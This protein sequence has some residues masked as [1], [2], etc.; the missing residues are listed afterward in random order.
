MSAPSSPVLRDARDRADSVG[1]VSPDDEGMPDLPPP[2]DIEALRAAAYDAAAPHPELPARPAG[3]DLAPSD[4]APARAVPLRCV[5]ANVQKSSENMHHCL[6]RHRDD[7]VILFA[8]PFHGF[9]KRVVSTTNKDGDAYEGSVAHRNFMFLRAADDARVCAFVHKRWSHLSPRITP[10]RGGPCRDVL[11]LS[12]R[13]D[14]HDLHILTVYNDSRTQAAVDFLREHV[15]SVPPLAYM[16]GDFNLRHERWDATARLPGAERRLAAKCDELIELVDLDL[17]LTLANDSVACPPTWLSNDA[18]K[19]PGTL[20]LLWAHPDLLPDD[21]CVRDDERHRSDHCVLTWTIPVQA[22][23]QPRRT[24][25]RGSPQGAAFVSACQDVL[26]SL[27]D[28]F[29][30]YASAADV[31]AAAL[32]VHEG[33]RCAWD[34]HSSLSNPTAR[35]KSWW[36]AECTTHHVA[37]RACQARMRALKRRRDDVYARMGLEGE[38]LAALESIQHLTESIL[39]E[40]R[41]SGRINGAKRGAMRRAKRTFF[42]SQIERL[43]RSRIWDVV[44]WTRA[45]KQ[46]AN[47]A[48]RDAAGAPVT[49]PDD[50]ARLLQEQFTPAAANA[51]DDHFLDE[52]PARGPIGRASFSRTQI[53]EALQDASNFSAPGPDQVS[54]FWLKQIVTDDNAKEDDDGNTVREA[55]P[56]LAILSAL[57]EACVRWGTFPRPFK[58]SRTVVIPKPGKADYTVP[59][60]Y[61]PIVLLNCLGKLLE[62]ILARQMQAMAQAAGV[63]H[64]GQFGGTMQHST[65]DAGI[66]L[67]HNIKEAWNQGME[68][69]A[70]LVDVAQFFPSINHRML[71]DILRHQGFSPFLVRFFEH[72][73]ADRET[74]FLFNGVVTPPARMT[75]GVGQGSALSPVLANLYLAPVIRIAERRI[76][77]AFPGVTLQFYVDDGLLHVF[78][79]KAEVPAHM[80]MAEVNAQKLGAAASILTSCLTRVGLRIE[81]AKTE[82]MHFRNGRK[83]WREWVG[84]DPL[85]PPVKVYSPGSETL[86]WPRKVVR[87]LGFFL[88]PKLSFREHIRHYTVKACSTVNSLRM[89]GNSVRGMSPQD[90][91][92][93]YISNVVPVMCYG[94]QLWWHPKWLRK[95][96]AADEM[97][98]AQSRAARWISGAFC[99]T[100]VGALDI[101]AGLLPIKEQ[102]NKFMRRACLRVHTLHRGHPLRAYLPEVWAPNEHNLEPQIYMRNRCRAVFDRHGMRG[103]VDLQYYRPPRRKK[104]RHT[105]LTWIHEAYFQCDERFNATAPVAIPGFRL[106]DTY[107]DADRLAFHFLYPRDRAR[108]PKKDPRSDDFRHWFCEEYAPTTTAA[109]QNPLS[110][111]LVTDGSAVRASAQPVVAA[112]FGAAPLRD[113]PG[114]HPATGA[115]WAVWQAPMPSTPLR[116]GS[117]ACGRATVYDAEMTALSRGCSAL[118]QEWTEWSA[119][120]AAAALRASGAYEFTLNI[121][122]DNVAAANS[123]F[124]CRNG[125]SARHA[126]LASQTVKSFLDRHPRHRVD[127]YWVPSH[128]EHA[129]CGSFATQLNEYVDR[130]ANAAAKRVAQPELTSWA[131]ARSAVTSQ[132]VAAW[133]RQMCSVDYRGHSNLLRKSEHKLIVPSKRHLLLSKYGASNLQ[134][135]RVTRFM[136]G[137][138]PSGEYRAKFNKDGP[139]TCLCAGV[140]ETRD[141]TLYECEYWVRPRAIKPPARLPHA[142]RLE[143]EEAGKQLEIQ[144]AEQ[145]LDVHQLEEFLALNPLVGTFEWQDLM[146]HIRTVVYPA[147]DAGDPEWRSATYFFFEQLTS[148]RRRWYQE[149]RRARVRTPFRDWVLK[150][151]HPLRQTEASL[152]VAYPAREP[153]PAFPAW[154][155]PVLR[156]A[157]VL[158]AGPPPSD[159]GPPAQRDEPLPPRPARRA[160]ALDLDSDSDSEF[161]PVP[162]DAA[163]PG[164]APAGD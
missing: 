5:F 60:A 11:C 52:L 93:L 18:T 15:D 111:T 146:E 90:K 88:D 55:I 158:A 6:E 47:M 113:P 91:R 43:H 50:L 154:M 73:L 62:K 133:H 126:I 151:H 34:A 72:Y 24:I 160:H 4:D 83:P 71:C 46:S 74:A 94:A 40:M 159:A 10:L 114:P 70:L 96:Y 12:L 144:A 99:T 56:V 65:T 100:P 156:A 132:A 23:P 112:A 129:G 61:R 137:H 63:M 104:D 138:Y 86:V 75:T 1:S 120:P 69:A 130:L 152:R 147:R 116:E 97:Q 32:R 53:I 67:V 164:A 84:D 38:S 155:T 115:G 142:R 149:W 92:R 157:G 48:L 143:L 163:P 141:H 153:V 33:F 161:D 89:L 103:R 27:P 41:E 68:S 98:K 150:H 29:E 128:V 49:A 82:L 81:A 121:F 19:R 118:V 42:D 134:Y 109:I 45:R 54:W 37:F 30:A 7:D 148:A 139:R 162:V 26:A 107:V 8:E 119:T 3:D 25:K 124:A 85:G 16:V 123:V 106:V 135:A 78:S 117:R 9:I 31:E 28:E 21:F 36:T 105:P 51:V 102:V 95:K 39:A 14:G 59:K 20:D 35:S 145:R 125:P 66:C 44:P 127:V 80:T 110:L 136:T 79:R 57:F 17:A 122:V 131:A 87:Y 13:V 76:N 64:P 140:P 77:E 22:A 108:I 2:I 58:E 101:S